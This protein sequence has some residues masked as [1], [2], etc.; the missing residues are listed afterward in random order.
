MKF[1]IL[2][3]LEVVV[4]EQVH[5]PRLPK[6]RQLLA[7]LLTRSNQVVGVDS[8]IE[9]IWEDRPPRSVMT[10][11]QTYVDRKSVV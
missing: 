10:T 3:P 6:V 1:R 11:L 8:L 9:E 5:V 7:M 4:D 2:G